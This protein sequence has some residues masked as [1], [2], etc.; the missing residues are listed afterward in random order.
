MPS[1]ELSS[2]RV[3]SATQNTDSERNAASV[4]TAHV[5]LFALWLIVCVAY[6]FA[7]SFRLSYSFDDTAQLHALAAY[8]SGQMS[9]FSWIFLNH[10]VHVLPMVRLYFLVG[11]WISGLYAS[12]IHTM[13]ALTQVA[14]ALAC[15]WVYF[16]LTR[17]RLGT[18]L[19]GTL[20]A[21]AG[22][23]AGSAV[24]FPTAAQFTM[25]ATP[26]V[27]AVGILVSPSLAKRW[28]FPAL[29]VAVVLC[30]MGMGAGTIAALCL[31]VYLYLARPA[32]L[33][34]SKRTRVIL[35]LLLLEFC[36]LLLN[37]WVLATYHIPH[38]VHFTWRG[39]WAGLFL[40]F[41]SSGRFLLAWVPAG[42]L[43][44]R[45]DIAA[46]CL[47]WL[48]IAGTWRRL[49]APMRQLLVALW[50]GDFLLALL[51]GLGRFEISYLDLFQGERYYT[52]FLLS[53]TLWAAAVLEAPIHRALNSFTGQPRKL[54]I[55]SMVCALC[56]LIVMGRVRFDRGTIGYYR[57]F[58]VRY[59]REFKEARM[60]AKILQRR[61]SNSDLHLADGLLRFADDD[62]HMG[63]SCIV[64]T[65]YP[66]G[67]K[68]IHWTLSR[69]R[70][71]V[72]LP[73]WYQVPAISPADAAVEN[74][75]LDEWARVE[76]QPP[77]ACLIDG[78]MKDVTGVASCSEAAKIL[79]DSG[80]AQ[81]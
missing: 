17:S 9:F 58:L 20:Y 77:Y 28:A 51:I 25:S 3:S 30:A 66:H 13:V 67:L 55:A 63:L 43:G 2:T 7:R 79:P 33:S 36:I 48:L 61:S 65:Q 59:E 40:I 53:F 62:Q 78:K 73:A 69:R 11:T 52:F 75:I 18:F 6:V 35:G 49:A 76:K 12:A 1:R 68:G 10:N 14:G 38:A 56:T 31:P 81:N 45:V 64:F 8:R 42:E 16:S 60:L 21:T 15:A 46:S 70:S 80:V 24:W 4:R 74:A 19:A 26:L 5:L 47:A 72:P 23:F 34:S 71:V 29:F 50:V 27:F 32:S 22:G 44:M 57:V 54:L 41:T 39:L 37:E